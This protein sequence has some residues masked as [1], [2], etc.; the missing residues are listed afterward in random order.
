MLKFQSDR[1]CF[2]RGEASGERNVNNS[3]VSCVSNVD[4]TTT[5]TTIIIIIINL[6]TGACLFK[7]CRA[8]IFSDISE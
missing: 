7:W 6:S 8:S 3:T 2:Q 1:A 4:T 5:T